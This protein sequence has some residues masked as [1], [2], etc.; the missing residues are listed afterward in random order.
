[1]LSTWAS[2]KQTQY[3]PLPNEPCNDVRTMEKEFNDS[4]ELHAPRRNNQTPF[5]YYIAQQQKIKKE[6]FSVIAV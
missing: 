6:L 4:K 1:M 3:S 2:A 5:T